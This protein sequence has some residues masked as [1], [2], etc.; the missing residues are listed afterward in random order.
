MNN[1][2]TRFKKLVRIDPKQLSWLKNNM[3]T[4]TIAGYLDKIINDYKKRK[5]IIQKK[6]EII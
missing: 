4:K 3:D 6:S 5:K 2:N 1:K